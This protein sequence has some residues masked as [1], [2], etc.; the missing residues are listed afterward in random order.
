M[1]G[2]MLGGLFS[3]QPKDRRLEEL[4]DDN[5]I[6]ALASDPFKAA[7]MTAYG[8]SRDAGRGLGSAVA[9]G[10]G[11]DPRTPTERNV[12]AIEAAKAEVAKLGLDPDDPKSIDEFY[13]QVIIILQKKGLAAEAA[14]MS[15]EYRA[16]KAQRTKDDLSVRELQRKEDRDKRAHE[17][18]VLRIASQQEIAAARNAT[19]KEIAEAK[20]TAEQMK[21]GP[22]KSTDYGDHV[23]IMNRFGEVI[24]SKPKGAAPLN[25]RDAAKADAAEGAAASAYAEHKAG[26]QQRYDAV[27]ALYAHPGLEGITGRIGRKVGDEGVAGEVMTTAASADARAALALYKQVVGGTFLAGLA[28]LKEASKT[29]AT[30]LGAVTE[31]EGD[32]VQ[33]DAAA[34]DR[35]QD[36]GPFRQQLATYAKE[37]EGYSARLDAAAAQHKIPAKPLAQKPLQAPVRGRRPTAAPTAPSPTPAAPSGPQRPAGRRL[38]PGEG[39]ALPG[40]ESET[41]W[42]LTSEKNWNCSNSSARRRSGRCAPSRTSWAA[43]RAS[44]RTRACCRRSSTRNTAC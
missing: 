14:A 28:K 3:L 12:A 25:A 24:S 31:R 32:K 29:G 16:E 44:T 38:D 26:V 18:G 30:G 39:E 9:A 10:M 17:L 5:R 19:A 8:A 6:A 20:L 41:E 1:A 34:L 36:A 27:V 40:T 4:D 43:V 13:K 33:S 21:T 35:A 22:F 15:K 42:R 23:E 11:K 2:G 7:A 37:L